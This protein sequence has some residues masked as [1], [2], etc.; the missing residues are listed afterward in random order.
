LLSKFGTQTKIS[1]TKV[2]ELLADLPKDQIDVA[3]SDIIVVNTNAVFWFV[4]KGSQDARTIQTAGGLL[5]GIFEITKVDTNGQ[6][7]YTIRPDNNKANLLSKD[8]GMLLNGQYSNGDGTSNANINWGLERNRDAAETT[9]SGKAIEINEGGIYSDNGFKLEF[10]GTV[11]NQLATAANGSVKQT[12]AVDG[13][14]NETDTDPTKDV[15]TSK[16]VLTW[17]I[18][19]DKSELSSQLAIKPANGEMP[20]SQVNWEINYNARAKTTSTADPTKSID[21]AYEAVSAPELM[22]GNSDTSLANVDINKYF[23]NSCVKSLF[24]YEFKDTSKAFSIRTPP[25]RGQVLCLGSPLHKIT[26]L[27]AYPNN[28]NL[29]KEAYEDYSLNI[30][31]KKLTNGRKVGLNYTLLGS[32]VMKLNSSNIAVLGLRLKFIDATPALATR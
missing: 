14:A 27:C 13:F 1:D 19:A 21:V 22:V 23:T 9:N 7:K 4:I 11:T 16:Y 18:P 25:G 6:V 24:N 31:E 2:N 12:G 28:D 20:I 3:A 32:K 30:S 29:P 8:S 15:G 5:G 10:E 17:K 26:F